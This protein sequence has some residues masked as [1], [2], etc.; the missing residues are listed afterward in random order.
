[1][2]G[3]KEQVSQ[4]GLGGRIF[5]EQQVADLLGGS[6]ARRYG[7]INRA[8]KDGSLVRLKRGTYA[9]GQRYREE[10]IH[11]FAVAQALVAGSYVSF[12][13]AL[14]YHGWIPEAVFV[15]ASVTPGRKTMHFDVSDFGTF[16]FHPLALDDYRFLTGVDRTVFGQLTALVAQPLR[17]LMDL[18]ALRKVHWSGLGWVIG[19]LRIDESRLLQLKRKD[20]VALRPVYKHQ[21]TNRFLNAL[22]SSLR[23]KP[24]WNEPE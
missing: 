2:N 19:G 13:T 23:M 17:A 8:L 20:F 9:L 11:P 3:L 5:S 6:P 4:A 12:E 24:L 1:M 21:A 16:D 15:T 22:E 10:T 7:V 14:A 18:V